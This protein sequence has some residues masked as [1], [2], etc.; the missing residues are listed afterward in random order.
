MP[1]SSLIDFARARRHDDG[2]CKLITWVHHKYHAE[3]HRVHTRGGAEQRGDGV[4]AEHVVPPGGT[5]DVEEGEVREGD[6][7]DGGFQSF[8]HDAVEGELREMPP[9]A[10][11]PAGEDAGT[12]GGAGAAEASEDLDKDVIVEPADAVH[13]TA[14]PAPAAPRPLVADGSR[15]RLHAWDRNDPICW[16]GL[17]C[18][19]KKKVGPQS[20]PRGR[21]GV[22][23]Q[24][25]FFLF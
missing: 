7:G 4:G 20:Q 24:S 15:S 19:I 23:N 11:P 18:L 21:N 9:E 3:L 22:Y 14:I 25:V 12:G 2:D 5:A 1:T 17:V 8:G 16:A 6:L 13:S 10:A